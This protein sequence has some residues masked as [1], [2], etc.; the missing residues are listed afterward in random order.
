MEGK[1][2]VIT[3]ASSGI[4]LATAHLLAVRG[5]SVSLADLQEEGLQTA[6]ASIKKTSPS[7]VVLTYSV[8]L[9]KRRN[10]EAWLDAT[11]SKFGRLDGAFNAGGVI[12]KAPIRVQDMDDEEWERVMGVNINGIFIC[13][14]SQLE[15][16]KAEEGS[17]VNVSSVAGFAGIASSA[18]YAASKVEVLSYFFNMY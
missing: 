18:H 13:M 11:N 5:A 10:V 3:G 1:V 6:S 9:T 4:G 7:A 12:N 17:I 14:S 16:M 2:F 15:R 8:N